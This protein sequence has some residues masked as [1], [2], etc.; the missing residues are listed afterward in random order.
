MFFFPFDT[1]KIEFTFNQVKC[2]CCKHIPI[3]RLHAVAEDE[4]HESCWTNYSRNHDDPF[5]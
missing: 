5:D 1:K 2:H 4:L 3:V